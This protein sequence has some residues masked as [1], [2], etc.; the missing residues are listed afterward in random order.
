MIWLRAVAFVLVVQLSV[1]GVLPW[2]LRDTGPRF[3]PGGWRF[4]GLTIAGAGTIL[5]AVCNALF[6][7]QGLGTAAPYDPPRNLVVAGP[8]RFVRNPMYLSALMI[9]GGVALWLGATALLAYALLLSLAYHGFVKYYEEPRLARR[10][11]L[12]YAAYLRAVPR[13]RP[14]LRPIPGG[15]QPPIVGS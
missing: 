8:Y 2:V 14:R 11:G 9:V 12:A 15:P 3:A 4:A 1:V 13:W 7:R 5:V 6:V 10:F